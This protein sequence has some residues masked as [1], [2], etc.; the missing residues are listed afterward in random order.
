MIFGLKTYAQ[1][2]TFKTWTNSTKSI[3]INYRNDWKYVEPNDV[4]VAKFM[5][6]KEYPNGINNSISL[7]YS[8]T[9]PNIK[10]IESVKT[11]MQNYVK[12]FENGKLVSF[13]TE[14]INGKD[15]LITT[16]SLNRN[17][18]PTMYK[19]YFFFNGTNTCTLMLIS[20]KSNFEENST[21]L[22]EMSKSLKIN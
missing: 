11:F 16:I 17:N 7:I 6:A 12:N 20:E 1:A 13:E 9:D 18:A 22:K 8:K 19:S 2:Q 21:L 10:T 4:M 3:S 14:K 5:P 15:N